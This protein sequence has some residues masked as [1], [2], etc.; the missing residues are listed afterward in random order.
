[1]FVQGLGILLPTNL[2]IY[3]EMR[4][5]EPDMSRVQRLMNLCQSSRNSGNTSIYN[6]LY[7]GRVCRRV[8]FEPIMI[9]QLLIADRNGNR[10]YQ[11]Y[12]DRE[13]ISFDPNVC[14]VG[15]DIASIKG[16]SNLRI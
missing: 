12:C 9:Y 7:N 8:L 14:S 6:N 4:K 16:G 15:M 2:R 11:K 5:N 13:H 3:F 10:S 1:M